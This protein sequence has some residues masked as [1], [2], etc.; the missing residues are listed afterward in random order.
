[1][2]LLNLR[3]GDDIAYTAY[4]LN[5]L[6]GKVFID[7]VTQPAYQDIHHI[8]LGIEMHVPDLLHDH[9]FGYGAAPVAQQVF[10]QGIFF[11]L[12]IDHQVAAPDL[13]LQ[14]IHHQVAARDADTFKGF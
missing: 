13:A 4:R 2:V 7:F 8:G 12:Q 3:I 14:Q 10:Q 6:V 1:M 5:E 9:G 11:G